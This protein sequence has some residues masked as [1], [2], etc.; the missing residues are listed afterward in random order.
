VTRGYICDICGTFTAG[1]AVPAATYEHR[2][3][4]VNEHGDELYDGKRQQ[5]EADLCADC[6]IELSRRLGIYPGQEQEQ[7]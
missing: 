1:T 2:A 4:L 3:L 7:A 5:L 6:A